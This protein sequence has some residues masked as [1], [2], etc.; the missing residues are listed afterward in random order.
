VDVD[1]AFES[2]RRR[3]QAG[4]R[5][6]PAAQPA[7]FI[8]ELRPYQRLGL[9]WLGFL[10]EVGFGGCLADDMGLGKTVQVLAFLLARKAAEAA[11]Q[12]A[13]NGGERRERRPSLVVAPRSVVYN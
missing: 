2:L 4:A 9:A 5:L 8:G 11:E 3:L 7:G 10:G 1:A 12:T 6:E 13:T